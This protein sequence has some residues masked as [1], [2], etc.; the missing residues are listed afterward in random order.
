MATLLTYKSLELIVLLTHVSNKLFNALTI[1]LYVNHQQCRT[2]TLFCVS[3]GPKEPGNMDCHFCVALL[4]YV[5]ALKRPIE[6][7]LFL[8]LS[9]NRPALSNLDTISLHSLFAPCQVRSGLL[10]CKSAK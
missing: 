10:I 9:A 3:A 4:S 6:A 2:V 8:S 5:S 1:F 7:R